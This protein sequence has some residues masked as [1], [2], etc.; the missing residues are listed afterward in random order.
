MSWTTELAAAET[1]EQAYRATRRG[2]VN[3]YT[4]WDGR[5]GILATDWVQARAAVSSAAPASNTSF[6]L[7]VAMRAVSAMGPSWSVVTG[8]IAP[9]LQWIFVGPWGEYH[10]PFGFPGGTL[11]GLFS[12]LLNP[13]A[14]NVWTTS[15]RTIPS[16]AF[17]P[18]E[19]WTFLFANTLTIAGAT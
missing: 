19:I 14:S 13:W 1:A 10:N 18:D 11:D 4:R 12:G 2:S 6:W 9:P 5:A 16:F 17:P 8:Q 15:G 7:N 3:S